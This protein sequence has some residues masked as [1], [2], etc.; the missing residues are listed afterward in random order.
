MDDR[1]HIARDRLAGR[2]DGLLAG[3]GSAGTGHQRGDRLG[4]RRRRRRLEL[5]GSQSVPTRCRLRLGG[6]VRDLA[7]ASPV[8]GRDRLL[9]VA[10]PTSH[11]T[12]CAPAPPLDGDHVRGLAGGLAVVPCRA[13]RSGGWLAARRRSAARSVRDVPPAA[14][15]VELGLGR[16]AGVRPGDRVGARRPPRAA[17]R[18]AGG[19]HRRGRLHGLRSVRH[20][21]SVSGAVDGG[22]LRWRSHRRH[23]GPPPGRGGRCRRLCRLWDLYRVVFVRS[24]DAARVRVTGA[25]RSRGPSC[26]DRLQSP[27]PVVA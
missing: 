11:A 7:G 17:D 19:R 1:C 4:V 13:A 9:P 12:A 24:D 14:A 22:S 5:P 20:R 2:R 8:D 6:V 3:V 16:R 25:V 27:S 23:P 21:L 15:V 18:S 10:P 26:R